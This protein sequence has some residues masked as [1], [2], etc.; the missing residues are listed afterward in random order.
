[1]YRRR[2]VAAGEPVR[3]RDPKAFARLVGD[4]ITAFGLGPDQAERLLR[5][6]TT[7]AERRRAK[8]AGGG[9]G[10]ADV[11]PLT[12]L[13][14]LDETNPDWWQA[15]TAQTGEPGGDRPAETM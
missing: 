4:G 2:A 14:H 15:I 13:R 11:D 3:E 9:D 8:R 7:A 12:L 5:Y 10:E 6:A 1:V